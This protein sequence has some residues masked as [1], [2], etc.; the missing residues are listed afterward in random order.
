MTTSNL[1]SLSSLSG[2]G[3]ILS[4]LSPPKSPSP[5]PS[6]TSTWLSHALHSV[7]QS[8]IISSATLY[9]AANPAYAKQ[10]LLVSRVP[11]LSVLVS[12]GKFASFPWSRKNGGDGGDCDEDKIGWEN[13]VF[14]FTQV[15]KLEEKEYGVDGT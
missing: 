4:F 6:S 2:T 15:V 8:G 10:N 9:R 7:K 1:Q 5:S 11:D 12:G 3:I 14:S 13:R